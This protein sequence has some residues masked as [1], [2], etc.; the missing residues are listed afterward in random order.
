MWGPSLTWCIYKGFTQGCDWRLCILLP[1]D[2]IRSKWRQ[3]R[4]ETPASS[5]SPSLAVLSHSTAI[6]SI[7]AKFPSSLGTLESYHSAALFSLC[8]YIIAS[9][10]G[11]SP[12]Y[13]CHDR[14]G[15][16]KAS[17]TLHRW[18]NKNRNEEIC[19]FSKGWRSGIGACRY[20]S[21][22]WHVY[23]TFK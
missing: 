18:P 11:F 3:G 12:V 5:H 13:S 7:A 23:I 22:G 9:E 15:L 17:W 8:F 10:L 1:R 21:D 6:F 2:K 16:W 4:H 14:W 19:S 20:R